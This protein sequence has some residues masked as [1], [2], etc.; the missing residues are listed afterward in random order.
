VQLKVRFR[1][2]RTITRS[3][4][5]GAPTDSSAVVIAEAKSLLAGVD[6]S[7]GVR[8]IGISVSGLTDGGTRQLSLDDLSGGSWDDANL[9]VDAI[10][11][12]FGSTA[13]GPATLTGPGG[14]RLRRP[15]EQPWGPDDDPSAT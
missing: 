3:S 11:A 13:I 14:L 4:T 5:L 9:A 8:L 7:P 10:R 2:F 15:G 6:P 12:R 1:D